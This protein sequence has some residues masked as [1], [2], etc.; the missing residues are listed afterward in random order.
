MTAPLLH[1]CIIT[2]DNIII[3][4]SHW[5][6]KTGHYYFMTASLMYGQIITE[7][8]IIKAWPLHY[9]MTTSL[10]H[11]HVMTAWPHHYS[12][13]HHS[14]TI[15]IIIVILGIIDKIL[16]L[17]S[18]AQTIPSTELLSVGMGKHNFVAQFSQMHFYFI[19][20]LITEGA[21]GY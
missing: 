13:T 14:I 17:L 6:C 15:K 20:S 5:Y 9:C 21:E 16:C 18:G 11:D 7:D 4:W 2:D 8:H 10:L 19:I 12:L 1:D 3:A